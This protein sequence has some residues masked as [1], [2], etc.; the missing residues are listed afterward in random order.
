MEEKII[1]KKKIAIFASAAIIISCIFTALSNVAI[2]YLLA[3]YGNSMTKE[4]L[5]LFESCSGLAVNLLTL[6]AFLILGHILTK[7]KRKTFIFAGS[8]Y[9]GKRVVA[10]ASS[11]I[12]S[13]LK[14]LMHAGKLYS[15]TYSQSIS[16]I[17]IAFIPVIILVAYTFYTALTG[18]NGKISGSLDTTELTLSRARKRYLC[19]VLTGAVIGGVITSA[20][21][22]VY[23]YMGHETSS[24]LSTL[25]PALTELTSWLSSVISLA[26]LFLA[27]YK[28]YKSLTE[29]IAFGV[30]SGVAGGI[31]GI[32]TGVLIVPL[33]LGI[34]YL[35]TALQTDVNPTYM[36]LI[37][38]GMGAFS[39]ISVVI[40]YAIDLI[41][42]KYFFPPMKVTL[43]TE[44][45]APKQEAP[46]ALPVSVEDTIIRE[47]EPADETVEGGE[48]QAETE[49]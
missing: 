12:T 9:F 11:L 1:N 40:A 25:A 4:R 32:F 3:D 38:I 35:T 43:F 37:S 26:L 7:D 6:S 39:V 28:A 44:Q 8:M 34:N 2:S 10:I 22:L 49:E 46:E 30:C 36:A 29:G 19:Y 45:T 31:S 41:M 13:T 16:I 24:F 14:V 18:V 42:L 15:G 23:V 47:E 48:A 5:Q 27:G 17:S 21:S 33:R 20:P